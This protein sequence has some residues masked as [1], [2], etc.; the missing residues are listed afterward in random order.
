MTKEE[1]VKVIDDIC[2]KSYYIAE[3]EQNN[4][5]ISCDYCIL[6][7]FC[8]LNQDKL[9]QDMTLNEMW[10]VLYKPFIKDIKT[11]KIIRNYL[12]RNRYK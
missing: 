5:M 12:E 6:N 7:E 9:N 2:E 10:N 4:D 8:G 1:F 3:K 11:R